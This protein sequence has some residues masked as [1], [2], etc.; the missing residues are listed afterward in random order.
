MNIFGRILVCT[1]LLFLS[2]GTRS[3][4]STGVPVFKIV[5]ED[6]SI[7]FAV[8][9]SV[10]IEG[11][12]DKW[13]STLTYTS[14]DSEAGVLDVEI[15]ADSV[16]TGSGMKNDK[17][18]SKDFFNVKDDPYITFHSTKI[19]QTGPNTGDIQGTF[20]I[21]G[22]SK[23]ETLHLSFSGKGTGQGEVTGTMVFDRLRNEPQYS[24]Y[25]DRRP[26][27]SDG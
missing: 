16:N 19:V 10:S 27:R 22:E 24:V 25:Q 18:K 5:N 15:Q 13:D 1:G 2:N 20:T 8:K 14:T 23:A 7:K 26:R 4:T 11:T 12:F 21:R 17:L 3:Q 6:S 9:A